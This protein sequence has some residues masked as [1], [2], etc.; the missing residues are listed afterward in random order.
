ML[1]HRVSK[2]GDDVPVYGQS[3]F[4]GTAVTV[5]GT[6]NT[7]LLEIDTAGLSRIGFYFS[8]ATQNLDA[9]IIAAKFGEGGSYSTLYSAA[10]DFTSPSGLL[11]G[12][13]GDLTTVAASSSGWFIM[14]V[15]GVQG[16]RVQASAAA[17]SA[18]V[19]PYATGV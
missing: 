4:G 1:Q 7:T 19:T 14:D 16:I 9:F 12:T 5:G 3:V 13:S 6:G 11:V 17:D 2:S 10:G 8:V 18:S 15:S